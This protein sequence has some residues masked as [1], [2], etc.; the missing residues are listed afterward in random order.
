MTILLHIR[1]SGPPFAWPGTHC[2]WT[3]SYA[4]LLQTG[5]TGY[6]ALT[7]GHGFPLVEYGDAP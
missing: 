7:Y 1:S 3:L 2:D 4:G 6:V 5:P